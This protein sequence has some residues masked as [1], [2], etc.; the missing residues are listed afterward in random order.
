MSCHDP[1]YTSFLVGHS[2][3]MLQLIDM[4]AYEIVHIIGIVCHIE[5]NYVGQFQNDE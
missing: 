3:Y 5:A 4:E 2:E 1:I